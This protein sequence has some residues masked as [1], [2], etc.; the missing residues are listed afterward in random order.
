M[1]IITQNDI[2]IDDA[3]SH[4]KSAMFNVGNITSVSKEE[5]DGLK[6]I[7]TQLG[8]YIDDLNFCVKQKKQED[9]HHE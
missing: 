9:T 6:D 7:V 3:C 5:L 8:F 1:T 4:M 2:A